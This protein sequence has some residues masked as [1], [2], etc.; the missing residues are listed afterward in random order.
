VEENEKCIVKTLKNSSTFVI[1]HLFGY[2]T[3]IF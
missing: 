3:N 2:F 1:L